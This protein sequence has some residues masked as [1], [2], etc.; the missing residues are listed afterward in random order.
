MAKSG[1]GE[2]TLVFVLALIA[3]GC[4]PPMPPFPCDAEPPPNPGETIVVVGD[5]QRTTWPESLFLN[6]EQNEFARRQLVQKIAKENPRF[7]VH[8][9]DMVSEG[10]DLSEWDYFDRLMLPIERR[11]IPILPTLGNH[12]YWGNQKIAEK[13]ERS[14]FE[15][16]EHGTS[17]SKTYRGIGLVWLDS[18][19]G[20][21]AGKEQ[22]DWFDQQL[23]AF[24]RDT[25]IRGVLVFTHHP[26]FT[27]GKN[28]P[29]EPYVGS[30]LL[31]SFMHASKTVAFLSGHV[32]G[33]ERFEKD[34][35]EYVVTGGGGGP[36]VEY[37]VKPHVDPSTKY[38]PDAAE[39]RP[40]NYVVIEVDDTKLSFTSR[41]ID[42]TSDDEPPPVDR[43]AHEPLCDDGVLERFT[44]AFPKPSTSGCNRSP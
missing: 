16:L 40:F 19:L 8:L 28:R 27:N 31:P 29:V 36:R 35:K 6:R 17:Y 9:G 4:S 12:E 15:D 32:H 41:C 26:P 33:Y 21:I 43:P 13:A 7:V 22:A 1:S 11:R 10:G 38:R 39:K 25:T 23:C 3:G 18:N 34:H 42:A 20:G 24:D 14:R 37:N 44:V 5:T 30:V 2:C